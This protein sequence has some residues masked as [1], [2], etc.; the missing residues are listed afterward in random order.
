MIVATPIMS[1]W[2][3]AMIVDV[4]ENDECEV[5]FVDYGG[6]SRLPVAS[7]RQIRVDFMTL[8]FQASECYLANVKPAKGKL[9]FNLRVLLTKVSNIFRR[10]VEPRG[11]RVLRGNRSRT[12]AT[13][14][15]H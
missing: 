2:Y 10:R 1:G 5:K 14:C 8:P 6:F 12:D 9:I 13:G 3:R 11:E 4:F 15:R 7:L